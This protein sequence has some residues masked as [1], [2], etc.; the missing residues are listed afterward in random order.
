MRKVFTLSLLSLFASVSIVAQTLEN[1]PNAK[2]KMQTEIT[3]VVKID[4]TKINPVVKLKNENVNN[5]TQP[6]KKEEEVK[7]IET[8]QK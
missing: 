4:K 3:P 1:S 7:S 5:N 8:K 2:P 6:L